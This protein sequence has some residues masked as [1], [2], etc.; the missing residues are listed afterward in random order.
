[1]GN[2]R[3]IFDISTI[4]RWLGPPVGIART[5]HALARHALAKRPDI[6]VSFYDKSIGG[7]RAIAPEWRERLC[8]WENAIDLVTLD[9]RRQLRGLARFRPSRFPVLMALEGL[10]LESKAPAMGGVLDRIQRL[11]WFPR[12]R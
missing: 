8:G 6:T 3:L 2:G 11:L 1:M 12:A 9:V 4:V 5:E 7:F 10:G